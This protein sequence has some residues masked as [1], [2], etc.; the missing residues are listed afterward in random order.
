MPW[1]TLDCPPQA[2]Q[3]YGQPCTAGVVVQHGSSCGAP[4]ASCHACGGRVAL[5]SGTA[6]DRLQA[7]RARCAMAVRAW[8]EGQALRATARIVQVEKETVGAWLARV[9]RHCRLV[10]LALW[11]HW[12]VRACQ[13]AEFWRFVP[14]CSDSRT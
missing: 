1:E 8:A 12:H 13:R 5:S 10:L 9:A 11:H 14:T 6:D 4:Q 3:G 2:C 7:D